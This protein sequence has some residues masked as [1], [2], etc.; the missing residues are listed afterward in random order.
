MISLHVQDFPLKIGIDPTTNEELFEL[1][2]F[3][4]LHA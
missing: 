3:R 1:D 4:V 2:F